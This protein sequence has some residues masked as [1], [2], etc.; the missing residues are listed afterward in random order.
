MLLIFKQAIQWHYNEMNKMHEDQS[1]TNIL[2][3]S[4]YIIWSYTFYHIKQQIQ[5]IVKKQAMY[6]V[7]YRGGNT[8]GGVITLPKLVS[9]GNL[10]PSPT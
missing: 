1:T 9:W 6:G 7:K 2:W 8:R 3:I 4:K 10:A 5:P